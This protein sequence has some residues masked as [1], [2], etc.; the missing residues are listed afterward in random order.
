MNRT[1][2]GISLRD[3][4]IRQSNGN[5]KVGNLNSAC[6]GN[7]NILRLNIPVNN[8]VLMSHFNSR[9][10]LTHNQYHEF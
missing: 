10:D 3:G 4:S 6:L 1:Q 9:E 7:Q 5:P 2:E 8:L